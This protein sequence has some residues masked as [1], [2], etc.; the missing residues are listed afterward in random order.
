LTTGFYDATLVA[1]PE[2]VSDDVEQ[3]TGHPARLF[4]QWAA[5]HREDFSPLSTA[6][7]AQHPSDHA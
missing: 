5:D 4:A 1:D 7:G 3:I 2:R 6:E